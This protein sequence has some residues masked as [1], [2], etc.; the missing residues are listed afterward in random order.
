MKSFTLIK[1]IQLTK[2]QQKIRNAMILGFIGVLL[3]PVF[4]FMSDFIITSL[5]GT[6]LIYNKPVSFITLFCTYSFIALCINLLM[7]ED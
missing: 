4:K 5:S 7:H 2:N 3:D 6:T 1:K